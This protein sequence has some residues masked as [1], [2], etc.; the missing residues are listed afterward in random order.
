M[1]LV[2]PANPVG[3]THGARYSGE[4]CD[5]NRDFAAFETAEARAIRDAI[6]ESKP[7]LLRSLH[8]G[9]HEGFFV[10]VTH[11]TPSRFARAVATALR[12]SEVELATHSNLGTQL[13]VPGVMKE[14]W[15]ITGVKKVL[16]IGS[17]APTRTKG[18]SRFS[19]RKGHGAR[20]R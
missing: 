3:I 17:P 8:E 13:K 2:A 15:L 20:G 18:R 14:G 10:L 16:S 11:S 9:P 12:S 19:P 1:D 7:G 6:E 4:G 5:V